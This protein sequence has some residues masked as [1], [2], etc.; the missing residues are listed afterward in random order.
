VREG[1]V[2]AGD[3]IQV[4]SRPD[5]GV[6]LHGMVRALHDRTIGEA[7]LHVERLPAFWRQVADRR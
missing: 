4:I 1:D 5:H 3:A 2:G 7:L 6:T